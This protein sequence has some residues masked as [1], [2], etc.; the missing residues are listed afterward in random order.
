MSKDRKV[1]VSVNDFPLLVPLGSHFEQ[2][3]KAGAAGVELVPGYKSRFNLKGVK[4]LATA[5]GLT[6]DSLHQPFWSIAG[7]FFD[8]RLFKE[9]ADVGIKTFVFHPPA[10]VPLESGKMARFLE[11]LSRLQA[12][13][14]SRVLVENMPWAVRPPLLR[15][16]LR[17]DSGAIDLPRLVARVSKYGLGLTLDTS[18]VFD[19][20]PHKLDWFNR[21]Y[22]LIGNIH[23]S[24]FVEGK[25]HLPL[26]MGNLDATGFMAELNKR[27]YDGL[28]TLEINY[29]RMM[30]L[31]KY[32]YRGITNSVQIAKM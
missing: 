4:D 9:A 19:P 14:K 2:L 5:S 6:V 28:I 3:K 7:A 13:T 27:Q 10:G 1:N 8:E 30:R 11:R 22:P 31:R 20:E 16:L 26:N 21:V 23:L 25:D 24:S 32:D 15:E 29:P 17:I 12:S 18:H